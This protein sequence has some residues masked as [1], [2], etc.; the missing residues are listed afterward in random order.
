MS[1][2]IN[3][4][5]QIEE[6]G[7]NPKSNIKEDKLWK[8]HFDDG[9]EPRILGR[10]KILEYL[11]KGTVPA[12]TVYS[13]KRWGV[14]TKHTCLNCGL[15]GEGKTFTWSIVYD[16]KQEILLPPK[17]FYDLICNGHKNKD[18]E[19]KEEISGERGAVS[20]AIAKVTQADKKEVPIRTTPEE[21]EELE[22]LRKESIDEI[23]HNAVKDDYEPNPNATGYVDSK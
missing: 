9:S 7:L 1:K 20:D 15:A 10:T 6:G 21:K 17:K 19:K 13:F 16:D 11:S 4:I 3:N 5:E 14:Q 12:K 8:L 18:E 23:L 2:I 22:E